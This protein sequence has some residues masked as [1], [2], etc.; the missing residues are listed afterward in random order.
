MK[1]YTDNGVKSYAQCKMSGKNKLKIRNKM[2]RIK[3]KIKKITI[4]Y[5]VKNLFQ[6]SR[7]VD[8]IVLSVLSTDQH[9]RLRHPL[10]NVSYPPLLHICTNDRI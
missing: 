10:G 5:A 7:S 2:Q 3:R 9:D 8:L 1:K 6:P 4:T